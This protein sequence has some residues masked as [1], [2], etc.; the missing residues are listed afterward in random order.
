MKLALHPTAFAV[1]L[2]C[3]PFAS[4]GSTLENLNLAFERESNSVARYESFAKKADEENHT[5]AA[6]LFRA[7]AASE[8]IHRDIQKRAI[9]KLGGHIETFKLAET[10]SA[11]TEE[12]LKAAIME[13]ASDRNSFYPGVLAT[14]KTEGFKAATRAFNYALSA[15]KRHAEYF[16]QALDQ[17]AANTPIDCFVCKDCGLLLTKLPARKC[18]VCD[19]GLK[20]FKKIS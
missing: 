11:S 19:E 6:K 17:L 1:L 4:A 10:T 20:E 15:E 3:S 7:A 9:I 14:A 2:A 12:N 18:P 13:E 8:A 5:Q 16:Q